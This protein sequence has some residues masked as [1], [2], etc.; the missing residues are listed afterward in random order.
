MCLQARLIQRQRMKLG[1]VRGDVRSGVQASKQGIIMS[2][3]KATI[4]IG[5]LFACK[6]RRCFSDHDHDGPC[7]PTEHNHCNKRKPTQQ[8]ITDQSI[9]MQGVPR[10]QHCAHIPTFHCFWNR[11]NMH[12]SLREVSIGLATLSPR[13]SRVCFRAAIGNACL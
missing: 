13:A 5:V 6:N 4:C 3:V 10:H 7:W 11:H 1:I 8:T 12:S 9:Q 2:T